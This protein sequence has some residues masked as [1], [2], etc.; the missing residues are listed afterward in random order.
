MKSKIRLLVIL[1]IVSGNSFCQDIDST[2]TDRDLKYFVLDEI[3]AELDEKIKNINL[4]VNEI[5]IRVD[6]LDKAIE[7]SRNAVEKIDKLLVRVQEIEKRQQAL[8]EYEL[9]IFQANYVSAIINL[10]SMDREIKPLRLFNATKDF[11]NI[12]SEISNPMKYAGFEAWYLDFK[13]YMD[14]Q[15]SK[16]ANIAVLSSLFELSGGLS[17]GTPLS[18]PII[19]SLFTGIGSFINIISRN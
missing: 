9:E 16:D 18:G 15:K 8:E 6:E 1:S 13:K 7:T 2:K 19:H 3:Q 17:Q 10:I 4:T 14:K 11:F 5:D 12:L